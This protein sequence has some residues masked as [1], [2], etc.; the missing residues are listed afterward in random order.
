MTEINQS[1][2]P[3]LEINIVGSKD[4]NKVAAVAVINHDVFSVRLPNEATI[5]TAEAKAI[6]LAFE[7]VCHPIHARIFYIC[8]NFTIVNEGLQNLS[9]CIAFIVFEQRGMYMYIATYLLPQ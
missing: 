5:F 7:Y 4:K 3:V 1:K 2:H 8:K 9:L 6:Q